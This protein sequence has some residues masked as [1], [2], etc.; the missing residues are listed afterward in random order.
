MVQRVLRYCGDICPIDITT[1]QDADEKGLCLTL[2]DG[3]M[4]RFLVDVD[5]KDSASNQTFSV[6]VD[7]HKQNQ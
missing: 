3:A 4:K 5:P 1:E 7:V 2:T 6:S